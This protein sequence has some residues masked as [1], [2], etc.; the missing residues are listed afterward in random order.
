MSQTVVYQEYLTDTFTH[1]GVE[2][3][4]N[5]VLIHASEIEAIEV[6]M[7]EL[8]DNVKPERELDKKR[9]READTS[10]PLIGVKEKGIIYI[11]DGNHRLRKL[12]NRKAKTAMVKF[13]THEHLEQARSRGPGSTCSVSGGNPYKQSALEHSKLFLSAVKPSEGW[14]L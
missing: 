7:S 14:D 8:E 10:F 9:L 11:L 1:H 13:I 2:Y 4:I 5:P 6:S 12:Y 3:Y